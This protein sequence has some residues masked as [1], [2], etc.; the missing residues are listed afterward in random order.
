MD[1]VQKQHGTA[2]AKSVSIDPVLHRELK[3]YTVHRG[4]SIS[5]FAE[6]AIR[7]KMTNEVLEQE[8]AA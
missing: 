8:S 1:N 2:R 5:S 6:D 7:E 4:Q 3:I